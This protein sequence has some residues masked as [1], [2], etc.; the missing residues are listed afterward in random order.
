MANRSKIVRKCDFDAVRDLYLPIPTQVVSNEEFVPIPQTA[1]QRAVEAKITSIA[2][3]AARKLGVTRRRFL[4][5]TGGMAAAFLALNAVWG[6]RTFDVDPAEVM[7]TGATAEKW[8]KP[9]FIFDVQTHHVAAGRQI[10][11]PP[12]LRYREFGG[13]MGNADMRGRQHHW[14]DLYLANYVKEVFLDSDTVV[15]VITGLPSRTENQNVLPPDEMVETRAEVN[16][17]AKSKR[18]LAHGLFS[19]ELG[20][21]NMEEMHR[22]V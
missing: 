19:P 13:M 6:C 9:Y 21:K 2:D 10:E 1:E 20:A 16:G 3:A 22:Q 7:E 11:I 18:L 4:T 5:S 15:A 12:L 8:P 17:L 14:E